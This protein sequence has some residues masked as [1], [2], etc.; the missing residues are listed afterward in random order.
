MPS[1]HYILCCSLLFLPS[2]FPSIG[3][4]STSQLFPSGGQ[5]IGAS[6]SVFPMNIQG[7][8]PLGLTSLTSLLS[9]SFLQHYSSKASILWCS[10]FFLVQLSHSYMTTEKILVLTIWTFVS[11][12]MSL[13]FNT[14]SRFVTAF[15]PR[16]KHLLIS[17]LQSPSAVL[18][19]P[20]KITSVAV[21][22]YLPRS[23]G[24]GCHD[25]SFLNVDFQARFFTLLPSPRGSLVPLYFLPHVRLLIFLL[26]ISIPAWASSSPAFHMMYFAW[27][28]QE[29]FRKTSIS[30]LLWLCQSLWL[31]GS[32]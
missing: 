2:I 26:V 17:W 19:K 6:A 31:C 22:I 29:S 8:F 14:L 13:L 16:S 28:K 3:V 4:F 21:S 11:K 24:T 30:A 15:L 20:R 23:D 12:E 18:L 9:K 27:K 32:Q 7:W 1:N 5:N 10:A 25:F